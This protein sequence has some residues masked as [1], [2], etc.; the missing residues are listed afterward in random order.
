MAGINIPNYDDVRQD[1]GFK[2]VYLANCL[3]SPKASSMLFLDV[4]DAEI[5]VKLSK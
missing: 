5:I 1:I 4:E 2:N 3:P